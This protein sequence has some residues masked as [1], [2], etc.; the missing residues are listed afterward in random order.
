MKKISD[1]P[2]SLAYMTRPHFNRTLVYLLKLKAGYQT[3]KSKD[4]SPHKIDRFIN[5]LVLSKLQQQNIPKCNKMQKKI[6]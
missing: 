5:H 4:S 6:K 2:K 1:K 3:P